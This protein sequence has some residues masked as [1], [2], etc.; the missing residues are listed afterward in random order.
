MIRP[1]KNCPNCGGILED[2]GRCHYCG[3]KIYDFLSVD[4][5]GDKPTYIRIRT[6]NGKIATMPI[7]IHECSVISRPTYSDFDTDMEMNM[8]LMR[9]IDT[10]ISMD[11]RVV[12]PI[13]FEE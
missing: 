3:S 9:E 10:T 5:D 6:S 1:L 2:T 7:I 4:F 12:G 11:A 8:M 13:I